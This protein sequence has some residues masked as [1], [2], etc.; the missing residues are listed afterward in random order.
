MP[1]TKSSKSLKSTRRLSPWR[2]VIYFVF[3]HLDYDVQIG[4]ASLRQS[5]GSSTEVCGENWISGA[6]PNDER[7]QGHTQQ[8][9]NHTKSCFA[10]RADRVAYATKSLPASPT[11]SRCSVRPK[12]T[13]QFLDKSPEMEAFVRNVDVS[14][15]SP[16]GRQLLEQL[17]RS[18]RSAPS[19]DDCRDRVV[20]G[21]QTV[22][23]LDGGGNCFSE[24]GEMATNLSEEHKRRL[25]WEFM[26]LIK[27]EAK[28]AMWLAVR[29]SMGLSSSQN[30]GGINEETIILLDQ[31]PNQ[32]YGHETL[33]PA[34]LAVRRKGIPNFS[35]QARSLSSLREHGT[36]ARIDQSPPG[37]PFKH[38]GSVQNGRVAAEKRL[39]EAQDETFENPRPAPSPPVRNSNIGEAVRTSSPPEGVE[40]A[41]ASTLP[42]SEESSP[43]PRSSSS[44][45]TT[46]KPQR[47]IDAVR[48]RIRSQASLRCILQRSQT[49]PRFPTRTSSLP[50]LS[51]DKPALCPTSEDDA[52][53]FHSPP[54]TTPELTVSAAT[55]PADDESISELCL[56]SPEYALPSAQT[57]AKGPEVEESSQRSRSRW[58]EDTL[59]PESPS[60][61][62]GSGILVT[63][64]TSVAHETRQRGFN[65]FR[66]RGGGGDGEGEGCAKRFIPA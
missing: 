56:R 61:A 5:P 7:Y 27:P 6:L 8:R 24:L 14:C 65:I 4:L 17:N 22:R 42:T 60:A 66:L 38:P 62:C 54:A 31:E 53:L 35:R 51:P 49:Q 11:S 1:T 45:Y 55:T 2:R 43:R 46:L 52:A 36:S 30:A 58:S 34:P 32:V 40:R 47:S 26:H 44:S 10:D 25:V 3:P 57:P 33:R 37:G 18:P 39:L 64:T 15:L 19:Q 48:A 59:R 16:K 13:A 29:E 23:S 41:R 28:Y 12:K 63:T 9:P 50:R 21:P 20:L